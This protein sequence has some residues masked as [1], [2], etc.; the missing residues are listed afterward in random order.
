MASGNG[1]GFAALDQMIASLRSLK[2][3]PKDAAPE[4]AAAALATIQKELAAGNDPQTGTPWVQKKDGGRALV[5]AA[6]AISVT[7][8]G[9]VIVLTATGPEVFHHFGAQ[10]KPRRPI[11]PYAGMPF[12][13]GDAI[14]KGLVPPFRKAMKKGGK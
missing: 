14:R 10:G 11:L 1:A 2:E 6:K 5:N 8:V 12:K 13:L 9:S 7:T 3:F 4:V